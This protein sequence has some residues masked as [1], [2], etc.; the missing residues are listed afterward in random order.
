MKKLLVL[1]FAVFAISA[2]AQTGLGVRAGLNLA[3]QSFSADGLDISPD[4]KIGF[5]LGVVYGVAVNET[6]T[7]RPGLLFSTKGSSLTQEFLGEEFESTSSFNYL[8]VP[9][10]FV[11]QTGSILINAGPYLGYAL[12]GSVSDGDNSTDIEFEEGGAKRMDFGLNF[13]LGYMITPEFSLN[14]NY[15]L[16]LANIDDSAEEGEDLSVKNTNIALFGIYSF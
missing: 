7:F 12:S 4:A 11:Y 5:Q 2:Y 10:D 13:G 16:G 9:L 3:N 1:F 15:G 6:I 8:E 14:L